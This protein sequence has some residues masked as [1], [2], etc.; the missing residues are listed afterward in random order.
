[1]RMKL[2][3]INRREKFDETIL[4]KIKRFLKYNLSLER[5]YVIDAYYICFDKK[6]YVIVK[7]DCD[8]YTYQLYL[9]SYLMCTFQLPHILNFCHIFMAIKCYLYRVYL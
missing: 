3:R 7:D 8:D 5:C 1:M 9:L 6:K 2:A 4:P